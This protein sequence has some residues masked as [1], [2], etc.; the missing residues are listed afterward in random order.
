MQTQLSS[1]EGPINSKTYKVVL[2]AQNQPSTFHDD[3]KCQDGQLINQMRGIIGMFGVIRHG[4]SLE[5]QK[6]QLETRKD[7]E[8]K[9]VDVEQQGKGHRAINRPVREEVKNC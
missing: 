2:I 5:N 3:H 7:G 6:E 4:V 1:D 8:V 9:D